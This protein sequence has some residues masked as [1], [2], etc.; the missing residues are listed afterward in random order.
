[1]TLTTFNDTTAPSG[2]VNGVTAL[3]ATNMEAFRDFC[4]AAGAMWDSNVAW[5]GNGRLNATVA[6]TVLN[7][8][9]AGTA[10]L[11]QTSIGSY[12]YAM[13]ILSGFR[14]GGSNQTIALPTAFTVG[15]NIRTGHNGS[16]TGFNGFQLLSS[17]SAQTINV[18]TSLSSGG[19]S[20]S[21]I[22][23]M[24][25]DSFGSVQH[26]FDTIQFMSSSSSTAN[27]LIELS[28]Q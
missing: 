18:I 10:T 13:I 2:F 21:G 24:F 27:G 12:K 19:G 1:M 8:G 4:K 22:T 3:N 9:N 6:S 14:T 26:T 28:G 15:A 20:T 7:G 5:D 23:T 25:G 11:Y 16:A 17:G